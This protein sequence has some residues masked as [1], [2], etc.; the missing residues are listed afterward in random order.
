[1]S[2]ALFIVACFLSGLIVGG[3]IALAAVRRA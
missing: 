3:L 1:M 2:A